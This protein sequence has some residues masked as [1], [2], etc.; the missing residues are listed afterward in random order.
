[1]NR[2]NWKRTYFR[3]LFVYVM[4]FGQAIYFL[5][6]VFSDRIGSSFKLLAANILFAERGTPL[7]GE[8][9][10]T[11]QAA[12]PGPSL[13]FPAYSMLAEDTIPNWLYNTDPLT[14]VVG[15]GILVSWGMAYGLLSRHH[16]LE[17]MIADYKKKE[18]AYQHALVDQKMIS[19]RTQINPHFLSNSMSVIGAFILERTPLQAYQYLQGFSELMRD[20]LEKSTEPFLPLKDELH[21]LDAF[22]Q[23]LSLQLPENKLKW[24][25]TVD[26][27][28]DKNRT[29]MP[30][31][32][33][34]PLVENAIEHG[35]RPKDGH[36]QI[37]ISLAEVDGILVCIVE[38]DGV[39]RSSKPN[40]LNLEHNS[41]ALSITRQRLQLMSEDQAPSYE[42]R[43][44]DLVNE[45]GLPQGTRVQ[46]KLPL[47]TVDDVSK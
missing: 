34:Q 1:M 33:L 25:F 18:T 11:H 20:V 39:G 30:P 36:G 16:Q 45:Q 19:L 15:L 44:F 29:L 14:I 13:S 32:I 31:M 7:I 47:L 2:K 21:F 24:H 8:G 27:K 35:I 22:L 26:S 43:T 41:M 40:R 46:V 17:H 9:T 42:L 3:A 28:L 37:S 38:D 6:F 4:V 10:F 12:I 23:N 5:A